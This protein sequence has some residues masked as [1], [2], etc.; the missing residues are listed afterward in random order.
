MYLCKQVATYSCKNG[1]GMGTGGGGGR[2]IGKNS[3]YICYVQMVMG[4]P[5]AF[6][7]NRFENNCNDLK[8]KIKQS[9]QF[10]LAVK[11]LRNLA[12]PVPLGDLEKKSKCHLSRILLKEPVPERI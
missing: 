7:M 12:R 11:V 2:H 6:R 9:L 10:M 4:H 5:L 1:G 3:V 8:W